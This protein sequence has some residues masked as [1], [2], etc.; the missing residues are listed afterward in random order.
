MEYGVLILL[1]ALFFLGVP[2]AISL[3]CV[4]L[5][6]FMFISDAPLIVIAQN[7]VAKLDNFVYLAVLFF[8]L[9]GNIMARGQM[10]TRIINLARIFVGPARGGLAMSGIVACALFGAIC[11]SGTATIIAV[12]TLIVPSLIKQ[13]YDKYFS[14]GLIGASG[15][16][17]MIVPPSVP[18]ILYAVITGTSVAKMFSAGFIPAI[19]IIISL[20]LYSYYVASKTRVEK[21]KIPTLKEMLLAIKEASIPLILI[22]IIFGGIYSGIFSATEAGAVA[23][24]FAFISEVVVYKEIKLKDFGDIL[25]NS[26]LATA[27]VM[28]IIGTAASFADFLAMVRLPMKITD[29]IVSNM[30]SQMI[31]LLV[32]NLFLLVIGAFLEIA[33]AIIILMPLFAPVIKTFGIDPIHFGIIFIVNLCVGYITPPVGMSLYV[34]CGIFKNVEFAKLVRAVLPVFVI[35]LLDLLIITYVPAI[36][37]VVPSLLP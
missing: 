30:S 10:S 33:S 28:L 9:V 17:G 21:E 5:V 7:M 15:T 24:V 32:I 22:I 34:C 8:I 12:G 25:L 6:G 35:L 36:S 20:S 27:I 16:L 2:V 31:F 29:F 19:L 13:N 23:V 11:G 37:L 18:M 4:A 26:A 3:F 1:I 14:T